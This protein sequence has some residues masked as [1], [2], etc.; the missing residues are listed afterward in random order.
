MTR[1]I[2]ETDYYRKGGKGKA[3]CITCLRFLCVLS[4]RAVSYLSSVL[5]ESLR[6]MRGPHAARN[7]ERNLRKNKKKRRMRHSSLLLAYCKSCP[8]NFEDNRVV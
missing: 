2:Y 7:K 6:A 1:D 5:M 8:T 3:T 4:L